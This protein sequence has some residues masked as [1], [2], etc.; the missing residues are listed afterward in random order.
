MDRVT[1]AAFAYAD[2]PYLN[3]AKRHYGSHPDYAGEVDHAELIGRLVAYDGWALSLS[4]KSLPAILRLCPDDVIVLAWFKP[5]APP[6]GDHRRYNWEPVILSPVRYYGP[7]YAPTAIIASPPQFTFRPKPGEHVIGEKPQNFAHW[8]FAAAG[9]T[10]D[11][12]LHDLY[13]GSGAIARAWDTYQPGAT[14]G[15]GYG[16]GRLPRPVPQPGLWEP[17]EESSSVTTLGEKS[18]G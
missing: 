9:L 15:D 12:E 5:I 13:P 17:A 4:L 10:K 8:V 1:P 6:L 11:D 14:V 18:H 2:P 16:P 3:Q 7:G